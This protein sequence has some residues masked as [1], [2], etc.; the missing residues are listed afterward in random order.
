VVA[1]ILLPHLNQ[2][3]PFTMTD[4]LYQ[5]SLSFA[6]Q[7]GTAAPITPVNPPIPWSWPLINSCKDELERII[8]FLLL[9]ITDH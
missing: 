1:N 5:K 2:P 4:E 7:R 3:S 8:P 9:L 6:D